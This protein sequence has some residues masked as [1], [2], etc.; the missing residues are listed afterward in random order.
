MYEVKYLLKIS[1]LASRPPKYE[2]NKPKNFKTLFSEMKMKQRHL[3]FFS[4]ENMH[5]IEHLIQI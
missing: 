4:A 3:N 2:E 1:K 5:K